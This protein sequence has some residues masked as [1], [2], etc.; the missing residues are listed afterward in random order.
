MIIKK[1]LIFSLLF[2]LGVCSGK[3]QKGSNQVTLIAESTVPIYQNDQGLGSF[4]K[5]SY[6]IGKSAQLTF[7][8]GYSKFHSKNSVEIQ[9]TTTRLIPF[10]VGYKQNINKF[11]VEPQIGFG[12]LG[13]KISDHGDFANPSVGALFWA[14]GA[15]YNIKQFVIGVR[16]QSAH[17]VEGSAAGLWH[18]LNFHY[19]AVHVGYTILQKNN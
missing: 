10:L 8:A 5:G 17:A 16:F 7:T 6:G 13:G 4:I 9:K 3:A 1:H 19:T 15:G 14:L 18:N 11:Y 12:E 2:V